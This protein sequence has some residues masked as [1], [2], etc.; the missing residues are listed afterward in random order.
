L[1]TGD[2]GVGAEAFNVSLFGP[3]SLP[4]GCEALGDTGVSEFFEQ[5]IVT[6]SSTA[7]AQ[8]KDFF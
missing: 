7:D 8:A 5:A 3:A 1:F 2:W 6:A 4:P